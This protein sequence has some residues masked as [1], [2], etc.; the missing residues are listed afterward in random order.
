MNTV[1]LLLAVTEIAGNIKFL[2][3]LS[4]IMQLFIFY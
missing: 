3:F 1:R 4:E 2:T